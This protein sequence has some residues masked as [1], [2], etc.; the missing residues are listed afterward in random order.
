MVIYRFL[1]HLY[2]SGKVRMSNEVVGIIGLGYV[3]LPLA[4][5][6]SKHFPNT[7]G[8][9]IS[10]RRV[11]ELRE[12]KD[13]THE[14]EDSELQG[15]SLTYTADV[16]GLKD[17]TFLIIAV[18]TP[19]TD[20]KTPDLTPLHS[21]TETIAKIVKKGTV[22]VYESTVYPG[23]TEEYCKPLLLKKSGLKDGDIS[24][25]Y[26]PERINPGDKLRT[27]DKIIKVVSGDT[28]ES[29]KRIAD[30][31]GK[32]ITAGIHVASS[33]K[34]AE[35]AKVI[36][37]TQRD[38]NIAFV[39]ELSNLFKKMDIP[40]RD[41]LEAA[42]TKWNF[43]KFEPGLVGGHCIGVDPYYLS[44]KA[45]ELGLNPEMILSGRRTNDSMAIWVANNIVKHLAQ[46]KKPF[47]ELKVGFF[48]FTFKE[49][50]PDFRNSQSFNLAEELTT[51]GLNLMCH[52]PFSADIRKSK[53][54][55]YD[56][57]E[58]K[59]LDAAIFSVKHA[60]YKN[61]NPDEL[62]DLTSDK[63]CLFDLKGLFRGQKLASSTHYWEL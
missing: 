13:V 61:I 57:K 45:Q 16:N 38:I 48:G 21:A 43:L 14:V 37:N 60:D 49:D 51:Y 9:D 39:N 2:V 22:V 29:T 17:C 34:V 24:F 35:A 59:S 18:P 12:G 55:F 15:S 1:V 41:V 32:V 23:V 63:T 19:V 8:F 6:V 36:E 28:E 44:H 30:V 31:Y 53:F 58:M 33:I 62:L 42:A 47:S 40:T 10:E 4:V 3:G 54:E 27:V 5:H 46:L 7:V 52:D 26:S 20:S 25:G 56:L 50:V 11:M